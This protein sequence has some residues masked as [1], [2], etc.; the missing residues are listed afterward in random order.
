MMEMKVLAWERAW[1]GLGGSSG[2]GSRR[3][4]LHGPGSMNPAAQA[5]DPRAT[6][7]TIQDP[8][9]PLGQAEVGRAQDSEDSLAAR[10]PQAVQISTPAPGAS[11]P[12]WTG[13]CGSYCG[14]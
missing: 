10:C 8:A 12:L 9:L 13:S 7:D 2:G 5:P 1:W 6:G 14:S 4:G 3:R 11:R